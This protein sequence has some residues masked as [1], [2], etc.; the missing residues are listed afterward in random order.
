M[1]SLLAR[2]QPPNPA[3]PAQPPAPPKLAEPPSPATDKALWAKLRK[4]ILDRISAALGA[5]GEL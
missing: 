5:A 1:P 3:A 4:W 2:V